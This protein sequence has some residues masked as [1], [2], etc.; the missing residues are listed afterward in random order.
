M[1]DVVEELHELLIYISENSY[2]SDTACREVV[3]VDKEELMTDISDA[4]LL[5]AKLKRD[6]HNLY[7]ELES[8]ENYYPA[9]N[10]AAD[11]IERLRANMDGV[12]KERDAYFDELQRLRAALEISH[13]LR[14]TTHMM[15]SFISE[16]RVVEAARGVPEMLKHAA[17]A[18]IDADRSEHWQATMDKAHDLMYALRAYDAAKETDDE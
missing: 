9:A 16:E 14:K 11:E 2:Y 15:Q 18:Y 12:I 6:A 13:L 17:G 3:E 10:G 4:L 8:A 5:I 1:S 7:A